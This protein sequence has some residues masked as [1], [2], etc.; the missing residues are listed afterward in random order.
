MKSIKLLIFLLF[1]FVSAQVKADD[2]NTKKMELITKDILETMVK[3][4]NTAE[5][6]RKY[7]SEDWLEKKKLNIKKYKINNYSPQTYEIIYSGSDVCIATI[8]GSSWS[9]LLVFK[10]T[11]EWGKYKVVPRGISEASADYIDPWYSVKDYLCSETIK[12]EE[13]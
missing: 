12:E 9:H 7:I 11:E 10:F 8:G 5:I 2:L 13:K 6:L 3:Q 4:E 1:V